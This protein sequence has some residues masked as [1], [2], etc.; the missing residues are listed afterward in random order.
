MDQ[1]SLNLSTRA[2]LLALALLLLP[3]L[4]A[5][6]ATEPAAPAVEE[7]VEADDGPAAADEGHEAPGEG[8]AAES[9]APAEAEPEA[10]EEESADEPGHTEADLIGGA[11]QLI[12]AGERSG[13]GYF[14]ADGRKL[15][16]QSERE[17]DNPYYQIY[18]LDLETGDNTRISPGIGKT[19][20]GWIHP[21]GDAVLFASTHDDPEALAEMQAEIDFRN[22][23]ET[24]RYSWDYD[25]Y[26]DIF[27][28]SLEGERDDEGNLVDA[29]YLNLTKAL[30]Y[31]AEGSYSPD[32]GKI[33]FASN[34]HAYGAT[35]EEILL[36]GEA[37]ETFAFDPS[38]QMDIYIMDADGS[39]VQRLTDVEGYDGGP[40]FS[41][42]GSRIVWRRFNLEGDKAEVWTMA[43]DGSGAQQLTRLGA[44]SWAPFYHPSGEYIVFATN[45]HGFGNFEVY[46]VD[47]A[48]EKEPVRVT[49][50]DGPDVLP[51]FSP[52]GEKLAWSTRRGAD[53]KS[54][55]FIADWNHDKA[56]E[57]LAAGL[58]RGETTYAGGDVTVAAPDLAST[59]VAIE[60]DDARLHVERLAS[61]EFE[62][63]ATGT[64]GEAKATAYV[65]EVFEALGLV[66]EGDDGSYFQAFSFTSG[67]SLGG[68]NALSVKDATGETIE[69][70][71]EL[72]TDWR[73]LA[74][75]KN[76]SAGFG[77]M[78]FA[79]YG[80]VAPAD[81]DQKDYDSYEDL[82]VEGKWVVVL[83]Y[84]PEDISPERRQHLARYASLRYKAMQARDRGATGMLVVTGPNAEVKDELVNLDFDSS[85]AG[86][87]I[88]AASVSNAAAEGWFEAAGTTLAEA[89][90]ALDGGEEVAGFGLGGLSSG[91]HFELSF[92][93]GAGRNVLGRLQLG[94]AP[95][96]E[97][98]VVGAHVDHLGRGGGGDSLAR[99]EEKGEIHFGADDNA[100]GVA[101]MIE[102]A[103]WLDAQAEAGELGDMKRD[104][105]FGAWSGEEIGL[106]GAS[107]YVKQLQDGDADSIYPEVSAYLNM[108]MIG[109]LDEQVIIQG[110][111]SS[112][113][114]AEEI[115][116]R[117]VVVGL[118]VTLGEDTYLPT[119]A[120]SFYLRGVPILSAFTGAHEDYHSPRDTAD[121]ID[122]EDLAKIAQL[123]GLVTRSAA[124]LETAPEY[125]EVAATDQS[126]NRRMGRVYLGTI[127]DYAD[128]GVAG[129]LLSGVSNESPAA[130]AGLQAGDIIVELAG[131]T[132]ENLYDYTAVLD[133][134]EIGEPAPIV[135]LRD[136]ERVEL[137]IV[138]GSRE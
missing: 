23:G 7:S 61:E 97:I 120:T 45:L 102:I 3:G 134:L 133:N 107:H 138:P 77:E 21:D 79:G 53:G 15:V 96:E 86:T 94:E 100:S 114:W 76:G 29:E 20:C 90:T 132:L 87:S 33:A 70:G 85:V 42:D 119:D 127:P 129:V 124:S 8:E 75:S 44:M 13:E 66:P 126:S 103:Q 54:Q 82:D 11:R 37:A 137:E 65:A 112:P 98:V 56:L 95:S 46:M 63:R 14:S 19:T 105:V 57:L 10:S 31:N 74:F 93:E 18:V 92:D 135:V 117:N 38:S 73:P 68:I 71:L 136:G 55:L 2:G 47:A 80:I 78:V 122:Y 32:G 16:Y 99:E 88:T 48:G 101:G 12:L 110:V 5:C 41:P 113:F 60:A 131:Q 104:V 4:A 1:R 49:F 72:H 123:M 36:E 89:Q 27:A 35:P 121:K 116:K 40:F 109:R 91:A 30:G 52:D 118:P 28:V 17:A 22:S 34:R 130:E 67:V 125:V 64:E 106:L 69:P 81:G 43:L 24:R 9:D 51:V 84:L 59:D 111:A 39:N 128:T 62:G 115:E 50:T 6:R 108:D 58:E 26:Y 25:P 83:R